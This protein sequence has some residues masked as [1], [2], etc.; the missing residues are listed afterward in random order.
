MNVQV[1]TGPPAIQTPPGNVT[2]CAN[3]TASFSATAG[4]VARSPFAV[5][6]KKGNTPVNLSDPRFNV[7]T[8]VG[9]I[10]STLT[11]S[12]LKMSDTGAG[13]AG[14]TCE[15]TNPCGTT[16]TSPASLTVLPDLDGGGTINTSDLLVV[17]G[18]FG[19]SVTPWTNGD[20]NGD[21]VVN[22]AD[23][24]MVLGLMGTTCI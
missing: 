18:N 6:W 13:A 14:Y 11:I 10:T 1:L 15:F 12:N 19:Y 24:T 2:K 21:G 8:S 9:G 7:T 17:L 22:T 5:V 3:K 4:T 20:L 23:L 16:P